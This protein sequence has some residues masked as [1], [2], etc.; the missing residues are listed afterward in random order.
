VVRR[1]VVLHEGEV[2][3]DTSKHQ[4]LNQPQHPHTRRI[5]ASAKQSSALLRQATQSSAQ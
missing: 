3:E 2:V 1:V 5:V 4:L